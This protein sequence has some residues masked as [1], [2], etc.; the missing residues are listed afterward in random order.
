MT[1]AT[2]H[3]T[4]FAVE[5]FE[6]E[7]VAVQVNT[8]PNCLFFLV[9]DTKKFKLLSETVTDLR[10]C[11]ISFLGLQLIAMY[12]FLFRSRGALYGQTD[13][14]RDICSVHLYS[15]VSWRPMNESAVPRDGIYHMELFKV[16]YQTHFVPPTSVRVRYDVSKVHLSPGPRFGYLIKQRQRSG[17]TS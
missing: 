8:M 12:M 4:V 13:S 16:S 1:L 6:P 14:H 11:S 17:T 3:R 10:P 9:D 15:L 7:I 5:V 2:T